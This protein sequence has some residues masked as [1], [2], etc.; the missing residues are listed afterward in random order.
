MGAFRAIRT[1]TGAPANLA[2]ILQRLPFAIPIFFPDETLCTLFPPWNA[3]GPVDAE[4][5]D[6]AKQ[7]A[8]RFGCT[9]KHDAQRNQWCFV[10]TPTVN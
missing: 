4:S 2:D 3:D 7:F 6:A 9:L 8:S 10:R 5:L 1:M